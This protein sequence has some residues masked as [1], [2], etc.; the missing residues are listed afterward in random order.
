[1]VVR[2]KC[3]ATI[4]HS[5]YSYFVASV[6]SSLGLD[7]GVYGQLYYTQGRHMIRR[8]TRLWIRNKTIINCHGSN[9]SVWIYVL[10]SMKIYSSSYVTAILLILTIRGWYRD[11]PYIDCN[12]GD[13]QTTCLGLNTRLPSW[14]E[15]YLVVMYK[16]LLTMYRIGQAWY[17]KRLTHTM[18]INDRIVAYL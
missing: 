5:D 9:R 14:N 13:R 11:D 15:T 16:F 7:F 17:S 3:L 10:P 1:M 2:S 8:S 4:V 12:L 6:V 18:H